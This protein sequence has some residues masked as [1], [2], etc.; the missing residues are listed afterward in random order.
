MTVANILIYIALIGYILFKRVQ[1]QPVKMGRKLF[2]LP[3]LLV[4]IGY[5]DLVNGSGLKPIE[6]TLTVIGGVLSLGLGALRGRADKLST[7][8]GSPFVQWGTASL[9]LFVGNIAAKLVLDL[10]GVA[11]GSSS[12]AVG[13]SLVLTF[14]LTLLG[15]AIVIWARTGGATGLLNPPRTSSDGLGRVTPPRGPSPRYQTNDQATTPVPSPA[16]VAA[17]D[18]PV[19]RPSSVHDGADWLRRQIDQPEEQPAT[20]ATPARTST[21]AARSL[22][23]AAI[24]HHHNHHDHHRHDHER[25]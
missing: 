16:A 1:G 25:S 23:D 10:I 19:W 8:D 3:V 17:Q 14:G 20:S 13:K 2:I 21:T 4:V 18:A 24:E 15:E 22:A 11:A 5:G 7:R 12:S 6:I 9:L